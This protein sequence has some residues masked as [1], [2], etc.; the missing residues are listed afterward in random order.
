MTSFKR[1]VTPRIRDGSRS[2]SLFL[3]LS[4]SA[5]CCL[6]PGSFLTAQTPHPLAPEAPSMLVA[7]VLPLAAVSSSTVPTEISGATWDQIKDLKF[8]QRSDFQQG[9]ARLE[10]RLELQVKELNEKRAS[11]KGTTSTQAWDFAMKEME[12]SRAYFRSMAAE[13][14][15]ATEETWTDRREKVGQAWE[16][17]Q[18]AYSKVKAS[19]TT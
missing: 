1:T 6:L 4:L 18:T 14:A 2:H 17:T 13:T 15:K 11:F 12:E 16:R 5:G 10:A 9:L 19:T 7:T 3:A 8:E